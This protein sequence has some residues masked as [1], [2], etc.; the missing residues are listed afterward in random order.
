MFQF[1]AVGIFY[2]APYVLKFNDLSLGQHL[3]DE[4]LLRRCAYQ[5]GP[6]PRNTK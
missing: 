3:S 2:Q 1:K 6:V 4:D 5:R